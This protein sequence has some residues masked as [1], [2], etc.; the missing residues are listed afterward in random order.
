MNKIDFDNYAEDYQRILEEQLNFFDN[1]ND[2]FAEYKVRIIKK[3]LSY[4]P[5]KILEYGCGIGRNLNLLQEQFKNA[6]I[7]ACD[8]SEKSLTIAA[9]ENPS[10]NFFLRGDDNTE[11]AFDLIFVA[12]V[13]HHIIPDLRKS[14][15]K[16]VYNYLRN[17][18]NLFIFEHNPYNPI[19][20]HLVNTC[21]FDADAVLL[22]RRELKK[23]L[24]EAGFEVNFGRYTLYFPSSLKR[25]R[26][27]EPILGFLPLGGQ[28]FLNASKK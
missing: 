2:Y 17:G 10:V 26:F 1:N 21:P 28:Y 3:Y 13:F 5:K 16:D 15:L 9:R 19:T 25:L 6:D 18:G 4:E 22:T 12:L 7:Y 14:A 24:I 23:L 27:T 20:R 11:Q 8:I